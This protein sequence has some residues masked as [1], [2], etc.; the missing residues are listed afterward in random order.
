MDKTV[1]QWTE[2]IDLHTWNPKGY[3]LNTIINILHQVDKD[4]GREK[5]NQ[6][7]ERLGLDSPFRKEV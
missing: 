7:I 1:E 3:S 6:L 4:F 5:A 2:Q